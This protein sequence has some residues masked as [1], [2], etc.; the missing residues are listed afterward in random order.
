MARIY[1]HL[2][3]FTQTTSSFFLTVIKVGTYTVGNS[4]EIY[5][6]ESNAIPLR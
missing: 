4:T 5:N 3:V 2:K 6:I 1:K